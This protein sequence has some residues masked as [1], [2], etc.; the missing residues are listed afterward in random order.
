MAVLLFNMTMPITLWAM[1]KI[2]SAAKG[3]AFGL[4]SFGLFIGFVPLY[5]GIDVPPGASWAF[6]LM[7]AVSLALLLAG[8]K[9]AKL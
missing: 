7:A 5:L 9:E 2:F 1:A 4:L 3:F 6:A 8:L